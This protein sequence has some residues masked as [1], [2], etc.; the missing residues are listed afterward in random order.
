MA[1][2]SKLVTTTNTAFFDFGVSRGILCDKT[3]PAENARKK[4]NAKSATES[5]VDE[6]CKA[7]ASN[8]LIAATLQDKGKYF[9]IA[10]PDYLSFKREEDEDGLVF[11]IDSRSN[12]QYTVS[13]GLYCGLINFGDKLPQLE[14]TT[15]LS[16]VFFR[17]ILNCCCGIYV[18]SEPKEGGG[19]S[20]SI[21]GLLVQYLFMV[22]LRK[23]A[24]KAI[25]KKYVTIREKGYNVKGNVDVNEFAK[26]DITRPDKKL[27]YAYQNRLEIQPIVDVIY[28]ALKR[29]KIKGANAI[30]PNLSSLERYFR[31]LYSGV[32]P[33]RKT[34][35]NIHKE[36]CLSNSLYADFK[37][38]LEYA[39][40]LL[41]D[42]DISGGDGKAKS[43]S[44]F[45]VDSSF[46]WEMYLYHLLSDNLEGWEIDPQ[47]PISFYEDTFFPKTNYPDFV[48]TNRSTGA[49]YILD[50]KLKRMAFQG[51]DVDNADLRQLHA[52]SYY[53]YL[54][55]RDKFRGAALIYPTNKNKPEGKK[56]QDSIYGITE[57][58]QRFGVL[59]I[60]D[61][62]EEEAIRGNEASFIDELKEFLEER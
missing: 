57:T 52:Y 38:P 41:R 47:H 43:V 6:S 58:D 23:V 37:R 25:P 29:C 32:R 27:T 31:D 39:Q 2:V 56:N 62:S 8:S 26:H 15:G 30:L 61:P 51:V 19:K 40:Y 49:I 13:T 46:L 20:D 55:Y 5:D 35:S 28:C 18:D 44:G 59:T 17:R 12:G 1:K 9:Q 22:S 33:S 54:K 10:T 3:L 34:I 4:S 24:S 42:E 45:L 16:D 60:K 53:F 36:R 7:L 11:R 50:A 21:Y 14:I 48:L